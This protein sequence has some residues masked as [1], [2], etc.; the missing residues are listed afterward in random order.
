[1]L[2]AA[3]D[4]ASRADV[5]L[6]VGTSA[7]VHPAASVPEVTLGHGGALIEV[8]TETTPLTHRATWSIRGTAVEIV[9]RLVEGC[10]L[11]GAT[12]GIEG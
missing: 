6:V 12:P 7:L 10:H 1:M 9:P 11:A 3:F 5:C 4:A 2:D 8:N